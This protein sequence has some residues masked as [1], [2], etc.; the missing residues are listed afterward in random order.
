MQLPLYYTICKDTAF[1]P[2]SAVLIANLNIEIQTPYSGASSTD[3]VKT[4][5]QATKSQ[6]PNISFWKEITDQWDNTVKQLVTEITNGECN[7]DPINQDE[8]CKQ[9]GLQALCRRHELISSQKSVYK[10]TDS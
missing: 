7:V 4:G 3:A 9:C 5:I 6:N 2:I 8:T 1:Q 10:A